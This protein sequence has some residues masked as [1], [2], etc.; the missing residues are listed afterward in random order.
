MLIQF[1]RNI[2]KEMEEAAQI[3]GCNTVQILIKIICPMLKPAM[4]SCALFQFMWSSNDFMGPLLYVRLL[5]DILQLSLLSYLW[6]QILDLIGIV[7]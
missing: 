2:S 1:M 4:V 6:M 5:Q 7:Y 3:D